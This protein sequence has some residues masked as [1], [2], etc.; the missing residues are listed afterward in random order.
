MNFNNQQFIQLIDHLIC[1]I[2]ILLEL[3]YLEQT[4]KSSLLEFK[5]KSCLTQIFNLGHN[6]IQIDI[7]S[8]FFQQSNRTT[9]R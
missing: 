9:D 7:T 5:L 1:T 6:T 3:K 4:S 8:F 2:Q